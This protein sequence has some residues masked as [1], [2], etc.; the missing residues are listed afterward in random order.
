M[1]LL[2]DTHKKLSRREIENQLKDVTPS[3]LYRKSIPYNAEKV[4]MVAALR[5]ISAQSVS[6]EDAMVIRIER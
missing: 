1:C 5:P 2:T 6:D 3:V 4:K